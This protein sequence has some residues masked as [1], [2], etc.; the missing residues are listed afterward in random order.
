INTEIKQAT[1]GNTE[2]NLIAHAFWGAVEAYAQGGKAGAGAV[3]AVTGEVG[4]NI[5]SQNLFG[6]EPENLTEAEKRTVSELSQVAA[7]LAGWLSANGGSSLSTAQSVKTGQGVGKNA[8]ENNSL[9]ASDSVNYLKDLS[10]A[11]VKG[12]S[13]EA[14]HN[15]YAIL[16]Q[17]EFEKDMAACKNGGLMCYMGVLSAMKDG[18]DSIEG[19]KDF[20]ELPAEIKQKA[21][22]WVSAE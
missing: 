16:S 19:Y 12:E 15:N 14:I 6:K 10:E 20:Y 2:A 9:N 3:A 5:I 1:E 17:Q 22:D 21:I 11:Y 13:L 8:V 7:G 18:V 4:A